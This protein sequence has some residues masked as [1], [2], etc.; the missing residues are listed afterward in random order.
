MPHDGLAADAIRSR[1]NRNWI[2]K[3]RRRGVCDHVHLACCFLYGL[4]SCWFIYL[5][6]TDFR[7]LFACTA[8]HFISVHRCRCAAT[9]FHR[10]CLPHPLPPPVAPLTHPIY[11]TLGLRLLFYI[12]FSFCLCVL[13]RALRIFLIRIHRYWLYILNFRIIVISADYTKS[14]LVLIGGPFLLS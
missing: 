3:I 13:V 4:V 5:L 2:E 7:V 9:P 8:V 12:L 6:K 14:A 1:T 10:V 11:F